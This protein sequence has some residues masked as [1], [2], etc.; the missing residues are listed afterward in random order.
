[1]KLST[2]W[3]DFDEFLDLCL[4]TSTNDTRYKMKIYQTY[5]DKNGFY[6]FDWQKLF[7]AIVFIFC[8]DKRIASKFDYSKEFLKDQ[9]EKLGNKFKTFEIETLDG[10]T[11]EKIKPN[12][13]LK[14]LFE[15]LKATSRITLNGEIQFWGSY[16]DNYKQSDSIYLTKTIETENPIKVNIIGYINRQL[17]DY[18]K[19]IH[20]DSEILLEYID[21]KYQHSINTQ[22]GKKVNLAIKYP[23]IIHFINAKYYGI[24]LDN[25]SFANFEYLVKSYCEIKNLTVPSNRGELTS[26]ESNT[27]ISSLSDVLKYFNESHKNYSN[28]VFTYK[29]D[30]F[31]SFSVK[32]SDDEDYNKFRSEDENEWG[33][34]RS[35]N[36]SRKGIINKPLN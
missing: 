29:M 30:K 21:G 24:L 22:T 32:R 23:E 3:T 33:K 7:D 36:K 28:I 14:K 13:I 26:K 17:K 31:N 2:I 19:V 27:S 16:T 12:D 6:Q 11:S 20:G 25:L 4:K 9:Q 34:L 18:F 5:F 10:K 1:M 8:N 35:A 15:Q